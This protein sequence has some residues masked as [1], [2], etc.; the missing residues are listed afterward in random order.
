[1]LEDLEGLDTYHL[2]HATRGELLLRANRPAEAA[3]AFRRAWELTAN[4]AERRHLDAR[5][6]T[7]DQR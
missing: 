1:M 3:N 6:A 7:A 2:F 4:P 5:I